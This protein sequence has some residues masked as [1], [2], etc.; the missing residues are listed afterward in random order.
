MHHA[1]SQ[2]V[3]VISK[4]YAQLLALVTTGRATPG[5]KYRITDFRTRHT[6]PKTTD[7]NE[8]PAEVLT[9]TAASSGTLEVA[10][11][12]ETYPDDLI[13]YELVNSSDDSAYDRGRI[14]Y[15]KDTQRNIELYYDWRNVKF[16]RWKES[17]IIYGSPQD[18]YTAYSDNLSGDYIDVYTFN[19]PDST[20]IRDVSIKPYHKGI[21]NNIV[22]L[23]TNNN[24]VNVN[25]ES[26][27]YDMSFGRNVA[28]CT[29][30]YS[31]REN[32]FLIDTEACTLGSNC[33]SNIFKIIDNSYIGNNL[34]G[35]NIDEIWSSSIGYS[36]GNITIFEPNDAGWIF[37]SAIGNY[38]TDITATMIDCSIIETSVTG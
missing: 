25:M 26:D 14:Y 8:A 13:H 7:I 34:Y 1:I 36:C 35:S 22:F 33:R 12:S 11:V 9:V 24:I 17:F 28:E 31:A 23:H 16:R 10:A 18:F 38:V 37:D 30:G 20:N 27:C 21:L 3:S 19:N 2:G 4:T 6:I 32:K 15:R 5:Q 29:I